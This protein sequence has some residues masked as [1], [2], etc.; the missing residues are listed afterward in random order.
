MI[1]I[2]FNKDSKI[3]THVINNCIFRKIDHIEGDEISICGLN[4]NVYDC[5]AVEDTEVIVGD[6]INLDGIVD[7]K[8]QMLQSPE[9]KKIEQLEQ[10]VADLASLQLGV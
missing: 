6:I 9:Q 4:F 3:V 2:V 1:A 8:N 7:L 10:L 5:V